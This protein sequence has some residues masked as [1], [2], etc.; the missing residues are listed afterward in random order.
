MADIRPASED[1][2]VRFYGCTITS[3]WLGQAMWRGRIIA[4]FGGMFEAES[5]SWWAF[6][7]VPANERKPFLY[8]RILA[9]FKQAQEQGCH[10]VRALC[11]PSVPRADALM[12]RLGFSRTDETIDGRAVWSCSL[13]H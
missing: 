13:Q 5:G 6:L 9:V 8:R 10:T 3:Q 7:E 11:D 4:G 1:D 12:T 2:L